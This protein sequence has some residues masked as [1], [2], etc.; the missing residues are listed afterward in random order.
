MNKQLTLDRDMTH[1]RFEKKALSK[2]LV[3]GIWK[4]ALHNEKELEEDWVK[5]KVLVGIRPD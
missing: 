2:E 1:P 5:S 3:L 4:G